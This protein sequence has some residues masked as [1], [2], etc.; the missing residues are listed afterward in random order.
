MNLLPSLLRSILVIALALVAQTGLT[1]AQDAPP[2]AESPAK[3]D[4]RAALSPNPPKTPAERDAVL[5]DLYALLAESDDEMAAKSVA[6]NIERVWVHS[7][8]PTVD[9]LFG[10]AMQ[11]V[12][13]KNYDRALLFSTTWSSRRRTSRKA[14][15]GV[16]S[17]I[18]SSTM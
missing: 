7:G 9:L 5:S 11:A 14:G 10:R 3:M 18:S 1:Q 4:K 15:T 13:E 6:E 16:R 2:N 8:S 12:A 17:C